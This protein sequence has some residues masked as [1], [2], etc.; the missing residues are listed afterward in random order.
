M[1]NDIE[2]SILDLENITSNTEKGLNKLI[3]VSE[4]ADARS[5]STLF[6]AA[7]GIIGALAGTLIAPHI[8]LSAL[9]LSTPLTAL[10]IICLL[11]TSPSPRDRG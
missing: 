3:Q 4:K 1:K 9:L 2:S 6:G 10:G 7:G 5:S 11:Y 8:A